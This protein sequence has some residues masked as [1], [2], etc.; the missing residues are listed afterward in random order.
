MKTQ[1]L[2]NGRRSGDQGCCSLSRLIAPKL[3]R[4]G[5]LSSDKGLYRARRWGRAGAAGREVG[6]QAQPGRDGRR[7]PIRF[8]KLGPV[9][10]SMIRGRWAWGAMAACM[11]RRASG[12][13]MRQGGV[14]AAFVGRVFAG[15]GVAAAWLL[16]Y[17]CLLVPLLLVSSAFFFSA[18]LVP[19]GI[20]IRSLSEPM[21]K[22]GRLLA[23]V[24]T[25][26]NR[27]CQHGI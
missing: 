1:D 15:A 6:P 4:I 2:F 27:I 13:A 24:F 26:E 12:A 20:C 25:G 11:A 10:R 7:Q 21:K 8:D 9:G 3:A 23:G 18:G 14:P 22:A 19:A 16:A 17:P 5:S